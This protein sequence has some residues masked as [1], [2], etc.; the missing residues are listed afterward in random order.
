MRSPATLRLEPEV[1]W[2]PAGPRCPALRPAA[3]ATTRGDPR[4]CHAACCGAGVGLSY[5]AAWGLLS[6]TGQALG[7]PLV[8]LQRGR[9]RGS[10]QPGSSSSPPMPEP[11]DG[12]GS[13]PWRSTSARGEWRALAPRAG[14]RREPRPPPRRALR[15]LGRP[16]GSSASSPSRAASESLGALAH[17]DTDVA[18]FHAG[19]DANRRCVSCS[20][21]AATCSSGS[22]SGCRVSW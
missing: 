16:E 18:G 6:D 12:C 1:S 10:R 9:G 20:T 2:R 8:E 4:A 3:R 7:V 14:D 21:R 15:S 19:G 22:R 11:C 13:P 5:R 17:G